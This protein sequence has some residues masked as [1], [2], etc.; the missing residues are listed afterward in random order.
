MRNALE[1]M[2]STPESL[3]AEEQDERVK[4][5][6]D[7]NEIYKDSEA[8]DKDIFAEMRTNIL[9]VAGDHYNRQG[10]RYWNRLRES[11]NVTP[12]QKIRLT[13]NHIGRIT[14]IYQ[15]SILSTNPGVTISPKQEKEIQHQ[16]AA[17]MHN[18]VLEHI[19]TKHDLARKQSLWAKDYIEIGEVFTK[20][21]WNPDGGV[22]V[23]WR[24]EVDAEG[25]P[26]VDPMT[27]QMAPSQ[28]PV[29]SGDLIFETIHGFDVLRDPSVKDLIDSPY[30][31]IRKM[32]QVKELLKK[33][34]SDP[35]KEKFIRESTED[36][37]RVFQNSSNGHLKTKGLTMVR[38]FYYRP[39]AVYPKGY[40]YITTELGILAEGELPF[41]IFPI[42]NVGFDELT[43]SPRAR[44]IIRQL[45]PYQI[46]IN[47]A[48]SK[49]AE[50]QITIG[51]DKI[52][53]QSGTKPSTGAVMPGVRQGSYIGAQPVI[54]PGRTGEQ[55]LEYI[56]TQITE[57][58]AI[59]E[60]QEL[61]KDVS[62]GQIDPYT[63][64][65]RCIRQKQKFSFYGSKYEQFLVKVHETA[66]Q[67]FKKY[68]NKAIMIPVLG[69]NEQVNM[70]EF[71]T[72]SDTTWQIKIEPMSDDIETKMGKQMSL[73]HILQYIGPQLEKEEIGKFLRLS[74]YFNMEKMFQ[75]LTQN[76]DN[77]TNDVLALDRGKYPTPK[78]YENHEYMANGLI[79]RMKQ[80]D[81]E[82][83]H[84]QIQMNY[85]RKLQEHEFF[86]AKQLQELKQAE[87]EF[88]PSGGYMVTADLYVPDPQNPAQSKRVRIPSEALTW[89]LKTLESQ[90]TTQESVEKIGNQ[91]GEAD[92][93]RLFSQF[94]NGNMP[95]SQ[96][97]YSNRM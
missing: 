48:S 80:P 78:K 96:P 35:E 27:G 33:F 28:K 8:A 30:L 97:T 63:L 51:D 36:T 26:V 62:T 81:F 40:F 69:K 13:K 7:L 55:Y 95:A 4:T 77:L 72:S 75:N 90:G 87:S 25:Q 9:L 24:P 21:F 14:K 89:L 34:G 64:L 38:E 39:C 19:K 84:P 82:F 88:I 68:A 49:M 94:P 71:K 56:N 66:L 74:P 3:Q 44:S 85:E 45:R 65:F 92:V 93:A 11:R 5:I 59:A 12:D 20:V 42:I 22:Q 53:F 10:S 47:R 43:T 41:G 86:K 83:L 58:Y 32:E 57:M 91:Q 76:W 1:M 46:E 29:M 67:L 70:E 23:G 16:K 15:N 73:N 52:F 50:H 61:E 37:F 54:I 17:E 2:S 79:T 6:S 60:I 18:S 31:C